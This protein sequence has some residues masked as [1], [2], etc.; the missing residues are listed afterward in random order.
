M[1]AFFNI[2]SIF[3]RIQDL[4]FY[5]QYLGNKKCLTCYFEINA[6]NYANSGLNMTM[7]ANH[8]CQLLAIMIDRATRFPGKKLYTLKF[9]KEYVKLSFSN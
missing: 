8:D 4:T 1:S 9:F 5:K 2:F 3:L 6:L 7:I